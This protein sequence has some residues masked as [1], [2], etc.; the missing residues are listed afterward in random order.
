M[1]QYIYIYIYIH[2]YV[3]YFNITNRLV[4]WNVF[5]ALTFWG[6]HCQGKCCMD[7]LD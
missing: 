7:V 2:I 3:I 4:H 6:W 5:I 1:Y